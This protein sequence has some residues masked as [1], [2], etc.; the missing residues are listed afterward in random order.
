MRAE[1]LFEAM[2]GIDDETLKL[3]EKKTARA[4]ETR[5]P[6]GTDDAAANGA[7]KG[8]GQK[9]G[10]GEDSKK[11]LRF[12]RTRWI[13]LAGTVAACLAAL[14]A[15]RSLM[16]GPAGQP[17][18]GT[19]PL[20]SSGVQ[21]S[22]TL[23]EASEAD[24]TEES[25]L[26]EAMAEESAPAE[27]ADE[28]AVYSDAREKPASQSGRENDAAQRARENDAAQEAAGRGKPADSGTE[29]G[30]A[31]LLGD[32]KGSYVKLEYISAADEEAGA[33]RTEPAYSEESEKAVSALYSGQV[34]PVVFDSML[35]EPIY[36]VYLTD[37]DGHKD[38]VTFY[39]ENYVTMDTYPGMSMQLEDEDYKKILKI[40]EQ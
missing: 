5:E 2:N 9:D 20:L 28:E 32:Y 10:A 31:D 7:R 24:V 23:E 37:A 3:S 29:R 4:R 34:V 15:V 19:A 18:N 22:A 25:A 33:A 36:Y 21:E 12:D 8:K 16:P 17:S 38:K 6:E 11:V 40:F 27:A 13:A 26:D 1:D 30:S 14:I 39:S 35:G